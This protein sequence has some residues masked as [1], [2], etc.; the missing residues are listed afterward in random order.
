M[1]K[2]LIIPTLPTVSAISFARN[3]D[4]GFFKHYNKE[5]HLLM[6]RKLIS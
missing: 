3:T 5:K 2:L 4:N 1:C 6:K